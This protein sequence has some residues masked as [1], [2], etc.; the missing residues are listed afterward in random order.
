VTFFANTENLADD[1]N[2]AEVKKT[3]LLLVTFD[4]PNVRFKIWEKL[5]H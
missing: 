2:L 3:S 1:G 5:R 4:F